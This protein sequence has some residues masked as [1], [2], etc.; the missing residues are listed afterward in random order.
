MFTILQKKTFYKISMWISELS[1]CTWWIVVKEKGVELEKK[2]TH[3]CTLRGKPHII[4]KIHADT[5]ILN[6]I[7]MYWI[8]NPRC[9]NFI[10]LNEN[11]SHECFSPVNFGN[12]TSYSVTIFGQIF[13]QK[14]PKW[15]L[16]LNQPK[17]SQRFYSICHSKKKS[18]KNICIQ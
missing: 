10:I 6:G 9:N 1:K 5:D 13:N 17:L 3:V 8:I 14:W 7:K 15:P 11:E 2:T 18:K 4:N 12:S 16:N